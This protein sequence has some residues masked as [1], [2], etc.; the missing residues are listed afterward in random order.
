MTKEDL[1]SVIMSMKAQTSASQACE[2]GACCDLKT[3]WMRHDHQSVFPIGVEQ[4]VSLTALVSYVAHK[5]ER[6]EF[7]VERELSNH[8]CVPNLKCLPVELYDKALRYIVEQV[9][10]NHA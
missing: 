4:V 3:G 8:F 5:T 7:R 9:P 6:S 2:V 1:Q 10:A